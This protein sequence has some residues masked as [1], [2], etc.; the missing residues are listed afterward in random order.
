MYHKVKC[1]LSRYARSDIGRYTRLQRHARLV[2]TIGRSYATVSQ[3]TKIPE[4]ARQ[5]D[6]VTGPA[7]LN[8]SASTSS[9]ATTTASSSSVSAEDL[10][11]DLEPRFSR[12]LQRILERGFKYPYQYL[13]DAN[14][15][16][17]KLFKVFSESI[18]NR[19][20][21]K[22][23]HGP[24]HVPT[25]VDFINP[26]EQLLPTLF[27]SIQVDNNYPKQLLTYYNLQNE[28]DLI[29]H[30]ITHVYNKYYEDHKI[31]TTPFESKQIDFSNPAQWYP[32]ARKMKR[33]IIMH[34]GPTNSGKTYQSL[35]KLAQSKTGY[36]AGPLRLL[37]REIWDRYEQSG[38]RCNLI[39][40]EEVI[41]SIDE[42]G[43]LSGLA[44]GTIEMIPLHKKM[45]LCV[46]DEIQMIADEQRGSVWTNAVLGV[47]AHEIHLCGEE[48][49]VP[50]IE[51]LVKVT[52]DELI[53][54]RFKRLGK[55]TVESQATNIHSLKK[56]DC[57]V[58]FSK[59]KIMELKMQLET[60][61]NLKVGVVYGAL[62]PEIRAQEAE[63]F[64]TGHYDVLV[65]SDAI[66]MGLNLKI[67]RIVFSG[68]SKFNGT[69]LLNLT[70]SQVKQIA[71]RAGRFSAE[72]GSKE[73]FV[74]ALSRSALVY[75]KNAL[76]QPVV[77]IESARIWPTIGVWKNYMT[78]NSTTKSL[79]ETMTD[80]YLNALNLKSDTYVLAEAGP[81]LAI[82]DLINRD[83]NL[84]KMSIDDQ[85]TLA[86]C[87]ISFVS[88]T[89]DYLIIPAVKAMFLNIVERKT[90]NIFDLEFLSDHNVVGL[91]ASKQK[92]AILPLDV[93]LN[94]LEKLEAIHKLALLYLW[95]NQRFPTLFVDNESAMH[96]KYF[97]EKR[98]SEELNHM[99]RMN[100][101]MTD[102]R[103]DRYKK[104][105]R[106]GNRGPAGWGE[107]KKGNRFLSSK[108]EKPNL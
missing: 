100:R 95:L 89:S 43:H 60:E 50:L 80:F 84:R 62:P 17:R 101:M 15:N 25:F 13:N 102:K 74:T 72:H 41:A 61:T 68:I 53:V 85:F 69:E 38:V 44:S 27:K 34:V 93:M 106:Y 2:F 42:Y 35:Q 9:T 107:K 98:L 78:S 90:Q 32:E 36:Y 33:K 63:K 24:D 97:V 87:P 28:Q 11:R 47:L 88:P 75:I 105:A 66:G 40:G 54:K 12:V 31:A 4:T 45:D 86:E 55:L 57:L 14:K 73:G 39:T 8:S 3:R 52:G 49:A 10:I 59:R 1:G 81:K 91:L 5:V 99:R 37:A 96:F 16:H 56:G 103:G 18:L 65:A 21:S 77:A 76:S 30:L 79:V 104:A 92:T 7:S 82:L 83:W 26:N 48:S 94:G 46:I 58:A 67:S 23:N 29:E 71:G 51:K 20:C 19:V 6:G 64:N 22:G 70:S 108:M